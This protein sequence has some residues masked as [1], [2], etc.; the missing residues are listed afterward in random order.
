MQPPFFRPASGYPNYVYGSQIVDERADSPL[1]R[2]LTRGPVGP[3][4]L[5]GYAQTNDPANSSS[6]D[7]TM[8]VY[9]QRVD[10]GRNRYNYRVTDSNGVPLDIGENV[11]WKMSGDTVQVPGQ[12]STY[13]LHLYSNYQ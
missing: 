11:Q 13:Q 6:R 9:S 7:R 3:W 12:S 5:V 1:N 10:Q 2:I 4:N 8:M